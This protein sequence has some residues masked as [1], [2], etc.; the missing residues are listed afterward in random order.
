MTARRHLRESAQRFQ[1][2][3]QDAARGTLPV[4][5]YV[6][7]L[8]HAVNEIDVGMAGRPE[9]DA[10]A[11]RESSGGMRRKIIAS[12]IGLGLDDHPCSFAVPQNTSKQISRHSFSGPFAE[13]ERHC[14]RVP[15]QLQ[16]K[17]SV[18]DLIADAF[19]RVLF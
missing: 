2:A 9:D 8:V 6:Q 10:G 11:F 4:G 12:Q 17:V 3:N 19:I 1:C 14:H 16:Q 13:A 7:A 5:N 15:Q 18:P